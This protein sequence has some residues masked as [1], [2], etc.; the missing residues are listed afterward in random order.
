MY[1]VKYDY[2]LW[3]V[4][5]FDPQD[6]MYSGGW[7]DPP[8]HRLKESVR[9]DGLLNPIVARWERRKG[10]EPR[11]WADVGNRRT[12]IARELKFKSVP[13]LVVSYEKGTVFDGEKLPYSASA[14]QKL[15]TEGWISRVKLYKKE[16]FF[17]MRNSRF[18]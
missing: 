12:M 11:M 14:V 7:D 1:S 3:Y 6:I 8:Y 2:D 15:F 17:V 18:T 10:T 4:P 5:C 13:L 16:L 9:R